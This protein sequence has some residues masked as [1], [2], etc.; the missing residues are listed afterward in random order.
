MSD[1]RDGSF[2]A[3][4]GVIDS[5]WSHRLM[6]TMFM[7]ERNAE[8]VL[9]CW[10]TIVALPSEVSNP[11]GSRIARSNSGLHAWLVPAAT[12]NLECSCRLLTLLLCTFY[13]LLITLHC[14]QV[15]P[16]SILQ[17]NSIIPTQCL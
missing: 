14:L 11:L 7:G 4:H 15:A 16:L 3:L 6:W 13:N 17:Y 12:W 5:I 1:P 10:M 2:I 8:Q 9:R